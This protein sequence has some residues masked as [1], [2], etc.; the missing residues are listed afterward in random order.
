[1]ASSGD[2][3]SFKNGIKQRQT[4]VTFKD[5]S[6][7]G[8]GRALNL[9]STI[10]SLLLT[11]FRRAGIFDVGPKPHKQIL[12]D[13]NGIVR[14]GELLLVL[15]R[16][17]SGCSTFLKTRA[18]QDNGLEVSKSSDIRYNGMKGSPLVHLSE[19]GTLLS[20]NRYPCSS[21]AQAV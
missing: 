6:V 5:L 7:S 1:M 8:S 19:N 4:G 9:Q 17:G 15:G 3:R 2:A 20:T 11:P 18:G 12:H 10:G 13:F 16:P 21:H 14:H